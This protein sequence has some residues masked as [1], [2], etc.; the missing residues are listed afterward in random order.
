VAWVFA[1]ASV[2]SFVGALAVVVVA[3]QRLSPVSDH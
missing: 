1:A 2:A 3:I